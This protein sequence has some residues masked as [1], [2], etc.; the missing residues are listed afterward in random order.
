MTKEELAESKEISVNGIKYH[1][2]KLTAEGILN[3]IDGKNG[4]YWEINFKLPFPK[5]LSALRAASRSPYAPHLKPLYCNG[6]FF[7][8]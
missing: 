7:F 2:K 8:N 5:G 6:F 4:G 1:T 3:R